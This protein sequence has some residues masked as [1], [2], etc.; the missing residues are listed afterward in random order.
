MLQKV[1]KFVKLSENAV[2]NL[3][4]IRHRL[5][6][7]KECLEFKITDNVCFVSLETYELTRSNTLKT[8]NA[9]EPFE[10][11]LRA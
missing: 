4:S 3:E 2:I 5:N 10:R 1:E 6:T 7:A 11:C 9:G 8:I